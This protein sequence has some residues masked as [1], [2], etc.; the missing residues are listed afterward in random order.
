[1]RWNITGAKHATSAATQQW[2]TKVIDFC[3]DWIGY[4]EDRSQGRDKPRSD[5]SDA[6]LAVACTPREHDFPGDSA[7]LKI[8]G[9]F[10]D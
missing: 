9:R 2:E 4:P 10:W 3:Y 8:L 6:A 5:R 1:M 7:G